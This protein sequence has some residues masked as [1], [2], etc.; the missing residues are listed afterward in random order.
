[1]AFHKR[2]QLGER[3]TTLGDRLRGQLVELQRR[4]PEI[5]EVRGRGLM[6]GVELCDGANNPD[7]AL[8][9]AVL[10]RMKDAGF[11]LGKTGPGRNVLT[12]MPPLVVTP[13]ALDSM[14]E[15]LDQALRSVS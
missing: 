5:G 6:I 3:S 1:L 4:R 10:E 14:V 12:L 11:L 15:G 7:A 13:E 9:D 2:H 8:T